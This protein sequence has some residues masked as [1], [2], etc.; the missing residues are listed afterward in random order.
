MCFV[1][2]RISVTGEQLMTLK[3][4]GTRKHTH[5]SREI[6]DKAIKG[7]E[8]EGG[9]QSSQPEG[10]KIRLRRARKEGAR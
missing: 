4:K 8:V 1:I 6:R 10:I 2:S 3:T 7:S 9:E 5:K